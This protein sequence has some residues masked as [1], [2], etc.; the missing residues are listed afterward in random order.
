MDLA[1]LSGKKVVVVPEQSARAVLLTGSTEDVAFA[2]EL[3]KSIDQRPSS[4]KPTIKTIKLAY[5][6]A[7]EVANMLN[8]TVGQTQ[9]TGRGAIPTRISANPTP[10]RWWFRPRPT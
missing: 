10:I 3:I 1:A 4:D 7:D 5:G 2:E 6:K 8:Q 9:R